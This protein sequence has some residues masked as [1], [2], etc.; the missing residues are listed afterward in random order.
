MNKEQSTETIVRKPSHES[1]LKLELRAVRRLMVKA[2]ARGSEFAAIKIE[3]EQHEELLDS[4]T[5]REAT[6]KD[7]LIKEL[8]LG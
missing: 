1:V 5:A 2:T 3:M 7:N 4:L 6:A 8:G